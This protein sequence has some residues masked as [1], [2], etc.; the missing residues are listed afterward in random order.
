MRL[1]ILVTCLVLSACAAG[2]D[3]LYG[4][5][6]KNWGPERVERLGSVTNYD[7]TNEPRCR[8]E[9]VLWCGVDEAAESCQCVYV[10]M[11]EDRIRQMAGHSNSRR[12]HN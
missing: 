3:E 9:Q 1:M 10:D 7:L 8:S 4:K 2:P 12:F 6:S 5:A 11:A